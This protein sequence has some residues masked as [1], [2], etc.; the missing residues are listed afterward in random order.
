MT[1]LRRIALLVVVSLAIVLAGCGAASLESGDDGP[2]V[3]TSNYDAE[4]LQQE[5]QAS[6]Q[7]VNSLT[8]G[9]DIDM[10][11]EGR[12]GTAS[13]SMESDAAANYE[14]R[15]MHLEDLSMEVSSPAGEQSVTAE[16]YQVGDTM[17]LNEGSGWQS[18]PADNAAW[19][20]SGV[21]QQSELLDDAD[22]TIEGAEV[23]NDEDTLVVSVE[24]TDE[25]LQELAGETAASSTTGSTMEIESATVT[26][27]IA[28]E[29]PHY[30]M[31]SEVDMTATVEGQTVDLSMSY[32]M[33]D[34]E[35]AV[36][37]DVPDE[38]Q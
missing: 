33:D 37:I 10:E 35:E 6:M 1:R 23:V 26:Q 30:V 38:V 4:T 11:V 12:M 3:D 31:K 15:R 29:D 34:H 7:D 5:A 21:S 28:A 18:Q 36:T 14:A 2:D 16:A 9:M 24:P 8:M 32:T 25:S 20:Q 19:S 17:Y 27:Y 13:I 22:V